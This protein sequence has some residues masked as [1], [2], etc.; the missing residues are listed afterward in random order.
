MSSDIIKLNIRAGCIALANLPP[1]T[2]EICFLILFICSTSIPSWS[3]VFVDDI[4]SLRLIS[5]AGRQRIYEP[6]PETRQIT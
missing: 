2:V 3:K 1:L 6:P 5:S 4:L